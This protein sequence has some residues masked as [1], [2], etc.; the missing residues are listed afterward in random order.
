MRYNTR[1][2]WL[3]IHKARQLP[4]VPGVAG[5]DLAARVGFLWPGAEQAR[6]QLGQPWPQGLFMSLELGIACG[7]SCGRTGDYTLQSHWD[8]H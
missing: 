8:K 2:C 7:Q 6:K 3:W 4:G 1:R 5:Q